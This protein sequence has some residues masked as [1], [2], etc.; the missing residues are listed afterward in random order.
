MGVLGAAVELMRLRVFAI[1]DTAQRLLGHAA[2]LL[3]TQHRGRAEQQPT[4][5]TAVTILTNP[6]AQHF[7]ASA[8]AQAKT[9]TGNIVVEK[10]HVGL[11]RRQLQAGDGLGSEPHKFLQGS[12]REAAGLLLAAAAGTIR[13]RI[14][15]K[16]GCCRFPAASVLLRVLSG[17][18]RAC[19]GVW[20]HPR[21][22]N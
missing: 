1:G 15:G 13:K 21:G 10:D 2:C 3:S 18:K 22:S 14:R 5:G 17:A 11:R 12:N 6:R 7:A 20:L 9:E 4:G 16:Q 8:Y 19:M